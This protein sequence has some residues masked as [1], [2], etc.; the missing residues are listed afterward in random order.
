M[1][2]VTRNTYTT[3]KPVT[4]INNEI[5]NQKH[6]RITKLDIVLNYHIRNM[7]LFHPGVLTNL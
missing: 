5:L 1:K 6:I 7:L 4:G 3:M 2:S